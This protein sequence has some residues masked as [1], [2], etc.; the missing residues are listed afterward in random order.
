MDKYQIIIPQKD[1]DGRIEDW[2][3]VREIVIAESVADA[4]RHAH[5]HYG[6]NADV[7]RIEDKS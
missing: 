7:R 4:L 5:R 1:R 2:F 6:N 3:P